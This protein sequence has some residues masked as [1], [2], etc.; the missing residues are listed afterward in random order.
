MS[1]NTINTGQIPFINFASTD[2]DFMS[3]KV[4]FPSSINLVE[5]ET[6][7]IA[8]Q[9]A[10]TAIS[11]SISS[12]NIKH[13]Q[14]GFQVDNVHVQLKFDY[15]AELGKFGISDGVQIALDLRITPTDNNLDAM[16]L[17]KACCLST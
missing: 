1:E 4:M 12:Q 11:R 15:D 10:I 14:F 5:A 16:R 17:E 7:E 8:Y 9:Q 6:F 13:A 3:G 2:Y